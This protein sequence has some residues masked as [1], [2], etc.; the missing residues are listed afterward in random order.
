MD[1]SEWHDV[2]ARMRVQNLRAMAP[3]ELTVFAVAATAYRDAL[4]RCDTQEA[5]RL[6]GEFDWL[7][8]AAVMLQS[9]F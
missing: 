3:R 6:A 2:F 7:L 1:I 9:A 4:L 8:Q 5:R